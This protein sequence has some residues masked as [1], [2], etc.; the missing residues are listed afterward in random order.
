MDKIQQHTIT[1]ST[2]FVQKAGIAA[3]TGPQEPIR[4]MIKEFWKR[5]DYMYKEL[6]KFTSFDIKPSFGAFYLFPNISKTNLDSAGF[7]T[8][9]MEKAGVAVTPGVAFGGY[10][11]NIRISYA[12]SMN[13][14]EAAI[15]NIHKLF[16]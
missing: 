3:L 10:D 7:S 12:N 4:E 14:L 2:S 6:A 8:F 1:C 16:D 9:L 15:N 13:N 11:Q 5:H